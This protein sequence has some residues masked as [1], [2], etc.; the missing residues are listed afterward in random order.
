MPLLGFPLEGIG[1]AV[2][3]KRGGGGGRFAS[4]R[5]RIP[6]VKGEAWPL[7]RPFSALHFREG[8]RRLRDHEAG[9]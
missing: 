3:E 7:E 9:P 1:H 8:L 6:K 4:P 5:G 2:C